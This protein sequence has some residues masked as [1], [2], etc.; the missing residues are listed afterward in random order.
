MYFPV[1]YL[2]KSPA[3]GA[4]AAPVA[5]LLL[6]SG[7]LRSSARAAESAEIRSVIISSHVLVV[8]VSF[9][10]FLLAACCAVFYIWQYN[11]LKHPDR[12]A[13]FR[14]LPPLETVDSLAYHLV[15]FSLP[16]LTLGLALGITRATATGRAF[17]LADPHTLLSL[18]A[19]AVYA[20][21][22]TAR[23]AGGWR[24]TRL[25]YLLIAGLAVTLAIFFVPSGTHRFS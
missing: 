7:I 1:E 17:W 11:A 3:L 23:I 15:A 8:L 22:L 25:N 12:R 9:A 16:L 14:K 21:Y 4:L 5:S 10:L 18:L 6:F 13:L 24:G 20:G 2:A 19:W